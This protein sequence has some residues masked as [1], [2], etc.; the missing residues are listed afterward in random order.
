M[1]SLPDRL[2]QILA[3]HGLFIRHVVE[4]SQTPGGEQDLE[5]LL[6]NAEQN[7]WESNCC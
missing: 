3:V 4:S 5:T 6:H 2:Q 1:A 7:G